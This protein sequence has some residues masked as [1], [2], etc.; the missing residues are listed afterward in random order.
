MIICSLFFV[1]SGFNFT[2]SLCVYTVSR[3]LWTIG[4]VLSVLIPAVFLRC[5][6]VDNYWCKNGKKAKIICGIAAGNR[7][8][9][10]F[11][12]QRDSNLEENNATFLYTTL[13]RKFFCLCIAL[14][15]IRGDGVSFKVV[16]L[17]RNTHVNLS[18]QRFLFIAWRGEIYRRP[19]LLFK[20]CK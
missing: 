19:L 2:P 14:Q 9:K 5:I 8:F 20:A 1:Y 6:E 12:T 13:Y 15:Q 7:S 10:Q 16:I 4:K 17:I 11:L 18:N 3:C